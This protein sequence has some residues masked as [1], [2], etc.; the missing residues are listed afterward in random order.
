MR[1][2]FDQDFREGAFRRVRE[3]GKPIAQIAR[4]LGINEG[5]LGTWVNLDRRRAG[6]HQPRPA[7]KP[8]RTPL[9][10]NSAPERDAHRAPWRMRHGRA[11]WCARQRARVPWQPVALPADL[12]RLS[13]A[14]IV[15]VRAWHVAL[16]CLATYA[17]VSR[18][19]TQAAERALRL[20]RRG[21]CL[22][23][24]VR[25]RTSR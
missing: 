4:D 8:G 3:T 6:A 22:R 21:R 2:K 10:N 14:E 19:P 15:V 24:W 5:T 13:D 12:A 18:R 25:P 9:R 23:H 20:T 16:A 17:P 7:R 11:A 1:R